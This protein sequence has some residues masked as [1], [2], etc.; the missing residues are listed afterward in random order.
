MATLILHVGPGK[1]GSSSIQQ[2]FATQ[3]N[4]C[5]QNTHYEQLKPFEIEELNREIPG[6]S[7]LASFTEQISAN[8]SKCDALI[9]SHEYLFQCPHAVK[10]ICS[11]VRNLATKIFIIGYSRKQSDFLVS[12]YS[13]WLFRS[14]DRINE[15]TNALKELGLESVLFTGLERQIIAS[16]ANDFYSA[17]QLSGRSTLDWY[18]SYSKIS[19]LVGDTG[20]VIKC[21]VLPKKESDNLLIYDFCVKSELT[22]DYKIKDALQLTSNV[23][24]NQDVIEAVNNAAALRLNVPGPHEGNWILDV[25]SSNIG[26]ISKKSPE[27]LLKLKSYIDTYYLDSNLQLCQE[28]GLSETYFTPSRSFSKSEIM[29]VIFDEA[30][31]RSSN[32]SAII[33]D[34]Q[35]LSA[36]MMELCIKLATAQAK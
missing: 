4:P 2:F 25:L 26:P 30:Q 27:F 10:N 9:L 15:A 18:K 24:F 5:V 28:Y 20:A 7:I 29:D 16:I 1:C 21:G 8:L 12:A 14:P 32:K 3:K 17:R 31:R 19:Q 23:S 6:E 11:L 36:R 34:Y 35:I 33:S 22:L 13:Q